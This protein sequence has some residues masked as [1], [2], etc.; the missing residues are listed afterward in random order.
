MGTVHRID[1]RQIDQSARVLEI[2]S[3]FP[4]HSV[5]SQECVVVSQNPVK[6]LYQFY[7]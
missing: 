6:R 1:V 4:S 2:G 3:D 7:G 5:Y